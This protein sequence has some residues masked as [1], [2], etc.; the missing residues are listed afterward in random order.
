MNYN[1]FVSDVLGLQEGLMTAA[2]IREA[3]TAYA[4]WTKKAED[5]RNWK[6]G[7]KVL[8]DRAVATLFGG[9][10]LAGSTKQK[11]WGEKIRAEK[12]AGKTGAFY[13]RDEMTEAQAL[14]ACDPNGLGRSAHFWIENNNR[15]PSEIGKFFETQRR[16]LVD[17]MALRDAGKTTE[18]K[19]ASEAYNA[20]T[21][22]WGFTQ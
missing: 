4:A 10:A 9:K 17:A 21:A 7:K 5:R 11:V 18:F 15:L 20:L 16:M 12:L 6:A 3:Q 19:A 2:E 1:D 13:A 8:A 22:E 14:L